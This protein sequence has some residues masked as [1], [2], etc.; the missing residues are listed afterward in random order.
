MTPQEKTLGILALAHM[1][2]LVQHYQP[3]NCMGDVFLVEMRGENVVLSWRKVL[4]RLNLHLDLF[5]PRC[6]A[7]D[8]IYQKL[9]EAMAEIEV[10]R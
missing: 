5:S 10:I 8:P 3:W 7:H 4:E 6:V 2:G 1:I 9:L